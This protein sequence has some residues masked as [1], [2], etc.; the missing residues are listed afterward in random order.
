MIKLKQAALWEWFKWEDIE[1]R[2]ELDAG[3]PGWVQLLPPRR[4]KEEGAA[5]GRQ[6]RRQ[7]TGRLNMPAG[8][9]REE[10]GPGGPWNNISGAAGTPRPEIQDEG[11]VAYGRQVGLGHRPPGPHSAWGGEG[12]AGRHVLPWHLLPARAL[13]ENRLPP[14]RGWNS[15][16]MCEGRTVQSQGTGDVLRPTWPFLQVP[17]TVTAASLG[18]YTGCRVVI[19][20]LS[21]LKLV[22]ALTLGVI[23][24]GDA[25]WGCLEKMS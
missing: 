17:C 22:Q 12:P 24:A 13:H 4:G 20:Q 10:R 16:Q 23:T 25:F 15:A 18:P 3:V 14:R 19:T 1:M 21:P 11:P 9:A 8:W 6:G 7:R 5:C 2:V